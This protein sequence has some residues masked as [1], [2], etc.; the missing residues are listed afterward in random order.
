MNRI[1]QAV[2]AYLKDA[3]GIR[4]VADRTCLAGHYPLLAV[5]VEARGTVLLDGGLQA[6]HRCAVT[7]TAASDRERDGK[8]ALLAALPPLLLRGIPMDTEH[9]Q[10]TLHPL[11]IRTSGDQLTFS[12][13]LCLPLPDTAQEGEAAEWMGVLHLSQKCEHF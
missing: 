2:T 11:D 7:V 8:T 9:G 1:Q 12:L 3:L 13:E 4:A 10:R 6:E 5:A